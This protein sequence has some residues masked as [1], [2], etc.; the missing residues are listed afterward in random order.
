MESFAFMQSF[1]D[2]YTFRSYFVYNYIFNFPTK[3]ILI[4]PKKVTKK[5]AVFILEVAY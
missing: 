4:T 5:V 1:F 3:N 2:F